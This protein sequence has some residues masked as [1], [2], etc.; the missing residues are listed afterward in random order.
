MSDFV[1]LDDLE[2]R[3]RSHTD[4]RGVLTFAEE[5]KDILSAAQIYVPSAQLRG[6]DL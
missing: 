2:V 3:F 5:M 4:S 6:I 1:A